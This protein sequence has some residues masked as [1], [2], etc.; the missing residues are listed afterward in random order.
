MSNQTATL[1][2]KAVSVIG[3]FEKSLL[4]AKLKPTAK[5]IDVLFY[6]LAEQG[7]TLPDC[8]AGN[9]SVEDLRRATNNKL[10][11][12]DWVV[13]PAKLLALEGAKRGMVG[14]R[15]DKKDS[16]ASNA[17][18]K[19]VEE[20]TAQAKEDEKNFK[21]VATAIESFFPT[22]RFGALDVA[23]QKAERTRLTDWVA[24]LKGKHTS[25]AIIKAVLAEI[26][27]MY[28]KETKSRERV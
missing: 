6:T 17:E 18:K 26:E 7:V 2:P 5:N 11:N 23:R 21:T 28:D 24:S 14:E 4:P 8:L 20:A 22:S 13:K 3:E 25:E 15:N 9:F 19:K 1:S 10:A 16:I 27:K 12:F